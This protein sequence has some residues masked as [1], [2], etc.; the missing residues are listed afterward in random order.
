MEK[1]KAGRSVRGRAHKLLHAPHTCTAHAGDEPPTRELLLPQRWRRRR[2]PEFC[3]LLLNLPALGMCSFFM[4]T[5]RSMEC[6][7]PQ[8]ILAV[9][10]LCGEQDRDPLVS[11]NDYLNRAAV[12]ADTSDDVSAPMDWGVEII[13]EGEIRSLGH[14]P[15]PPVKILGQLWP[16]QRQV[17]ITRKIM[18]RAPG[19]FEP[20]EWRALQSLED[21]C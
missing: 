6:L 5:M 8:D 9:D 4:Y 16:A 13:P 20:D 18:I 15:Q 10:V 12:T 14:R 3:Y 2:V 17:P 19:N 7:Q 11:G 21:P 1:R